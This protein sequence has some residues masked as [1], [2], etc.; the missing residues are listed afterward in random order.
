MIRRPPR[1]TLFPY[2]TLFRSLL[3]LGHGVLARLVR[4]LFAQVFLGLDAQLGFGLGAHLGLG[5]GALALALGLP[6]LLGLLARAVKRGLLLLRA[7]LGRRLGSHVD[8]R[9][10]RCRRRR[11]SRRLR[12]GIGLL[13]RSERAE[14]QIDGRIE[15]AGRPGGCR[16]GTRRRARGYLADESVLVELDDQ[17]LEVGVVLVAALLRHVGERR[18]AIDRREH[19]AVLAL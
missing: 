8:R 7:A 4:R 17:P 9:R 6:L 5:L 3:G 18:P 13:R 1:S 16:G 11:R 10:F 14:I 2:T 19:R 15:L 12:R